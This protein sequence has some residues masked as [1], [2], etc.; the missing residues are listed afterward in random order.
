MKKILFVSNI[1]GSKIG[2]F[3]LSSILAAKKLGCEF[4]IA[5]NWKKSSVEQIKSDEEKYGVKI[6]HIDFKRSPYNLLNFKAFFQLNKLMEEEQYDVI[7]CNTPIGGLLGRICALKSGIPKIIYMVHGFHFYEGAPILKG[8]VY[9]FVERIMAKHTDAIITINKE[10]YFAAQNF[11]LRGDGLVYY[12]PGVG[13]DAKSFSG[14]KICKEKKIADLDLPADSILML[15]V[16]ELNK[17]K[18][19][20]VAIKAMA[21]IGNSKLHYCIAGKGNYEK[22][23]TSLI[24]EL[25]LK[26]NVHLLGYRNDICELCKTADFFVFPTIREGL[27]LAAIEAMSS[28]LPIITSNVRGIID[29]SINGVTGFTCNPYDVQAFVRAIET[30]SNNE[31]MRNKFSENNKKAVMKY[32]I[33][34][35]STLLCKIY[36]E[37]LVV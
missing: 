20:S 29:Y 18:N 4:H 37:I 5:A 14:T 34:N 1:A 16:G 26:D 15:S 30:L 32:D 27:G 10:D 11:T 21:E 2:N 17:N 24:N 13:F 31:E 9:R 28:G 8:N 25:G 36:S 35:I 19:H 22:K 3:S 23:L 6:H 33:K 12:I 7:H